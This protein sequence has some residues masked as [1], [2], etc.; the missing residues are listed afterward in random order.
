[1]TVSPAVPVP[2]MNGVL[3]LVRLSRCTPLSLAAAR[4]SPPVGAGNA[5]TM[6]TGTVAD[7][8]DTLAARSVSVV[9]KLCGPVVSG[10]SGATEKVPSAAIV[11]VPTA[12]P[13]S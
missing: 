2:V 3:T 10:S 5:V 7:G 4:A 6:V 11:A 1:M 8:A 9:V 13:L 12:M